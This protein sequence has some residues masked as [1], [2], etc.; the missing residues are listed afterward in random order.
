MRIIDKYG[1]TQ[2]TIRDKNYQKVLPM[3]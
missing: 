2:R 3:S 1:D